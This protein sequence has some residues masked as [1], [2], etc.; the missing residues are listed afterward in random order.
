MKKIDSEKQSLLL[1]F[2]DHFK[3]QLDSRAQLIESTD[4]SNK[5]IMPKKAVKKYNEL[6]NQACEN[7][8]STIILS[9]LS[10]QTYLYDFIHH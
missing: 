5:T 9:I 4:L 1:S 2:C 10:I 8:N 7:E 3:K 6:V